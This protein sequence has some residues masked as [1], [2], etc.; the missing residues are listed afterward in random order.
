VVLI[1]VVLVEVALIVEL[2]VQLRLP[3]FVLLEEAAILVVV[4]LH[5]AVGDARRP[6]PIVVL[7]RLERLYH[8]GTAEALHRLRVLLDG[9]GALHQL[10][11][12]LQSAEIARRDGLVDFFR[13]D[14][15]GDVLDDH[16]GTVAQAALVWLRLCGDGRKHQSVLLGR[17]G[18]LD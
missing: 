11:V 7:L 10:K 5:F 8:L 2:D 3:R 14:H 17:G 13:A 6:P 15:H 1:E 4:R 18:F 16:V 9:L 12:P